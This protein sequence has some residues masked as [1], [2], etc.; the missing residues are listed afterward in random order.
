[1]PQTAARHKQEPARAGKLLERLRALLL[2]PAE[3]R[4]RAARASAAVRRKAIAVAA[5]VDTAA[6]VVSPEPM[7]ETRAE[8]GGHSASACGRESGG[9][10]QRC[11]AAP[12][13]ALPL[14]VLG[15]PLVLSLAQALGPSP[16]TARARQQQPRRRRENRAGDSAAGDARRESEGRTETAAPE[17]GKQL[18]RLRFRAARAARPAVGARGPRLRPTLCRGQFCRAARADHAPRF[19]R[20]AIPTAR[21][22]SQGEMG[23]RC[24]EP[25]LP[26]AAPCLAQRGRNLSAS[27]HGESARLQVAL[28]RRESSRREGAPRRGVPRSSSGARL[29]ARSCVRRSGGAG[30]ATP[31][32]LHERG[33]TFALEY[34]FCV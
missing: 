3:A 19:P 13:A 8:R 34:C 5:D 7:R 15:A 25:R 11:R 20:R 33:G 31:S 2:S 27:P 26:G 10:C 24:R 30:A 21:G 6:R 4:R 23:E 14:G 16:R 12:A 29:S 22:E 18:W 32:A 17:R 9:C 28:A 1:M